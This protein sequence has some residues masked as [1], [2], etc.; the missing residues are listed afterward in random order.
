MILFCWA[1]ISWVACSCRSLARTRTSR[2]PKRHTTNAVA[3][4]AQ[5]TGGLSKTQQAAAGWDGRV[6]AGE[7]W[8]TLIKTLHQ[9]FALPE[10]SATFKDEVKRSWSWY[11][12]GSVLEGQLVNVVWRMEYGS[13]KGRVKRVKS[14]VRNLNK[15]ADKNN[16]HR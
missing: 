1:G 8:H 2:S 14:R 7:T 6:K 15:N 9:S 4:L 3:Y 13:R 5:V 12:A 16:G 10:V 11:E